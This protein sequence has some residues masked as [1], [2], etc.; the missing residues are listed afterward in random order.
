MNPQTPLVQ[1]VVELTGPGGHA[2]PQAPQF[3]RSLFKLAQV[4]PHCVKPE[5]HVNPQN[6]ESPKVVQVGVELGGL[7]Q[8][9]PQSP[10][11]IGSFQIFAQFPLQQV[12]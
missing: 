3:C 11:F 10:Q 1:V 5:L 9:R 6:V 12:S 7:G 8:T 4:F 2:P